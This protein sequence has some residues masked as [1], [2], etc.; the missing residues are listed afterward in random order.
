MLCVQFHSRTYQTPY[1]Y[2]WQKRGELREAAPWP[3]HPMRS[4]GD[5]RWQLDLPEALSGHV[6]ISDAG[7]RQLPSCYVVR[8]LT[9][10]E[11]QWPRA[12]SDPAQ[13]HQPGAA[14]AVPSEAARGLN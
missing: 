10:E 1:L 9:L 7:E 6:I 8:E 14:G 11:G 12:Q 2:F 5:G 4:M 3:G 13:S